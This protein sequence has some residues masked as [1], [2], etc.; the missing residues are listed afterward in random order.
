M[1]HFIHC[2]KFI[3]LP[4]IPSEQSR[5]PSSTIIYIAQFFSPSVN[6]DAGQV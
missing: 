1:I 5:G 4:N 2:R 6:K 3:P